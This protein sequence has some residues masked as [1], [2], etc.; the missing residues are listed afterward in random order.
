M[1]DFN[2]NDLSERE[3]AAGAAITM[4]TLRE[5][6]KEELKEARKKSS[7]KSEVISALFVII[8]SIAMLTLMIF[9]SP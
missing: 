3:L 6:Q 9:M 1:S 5:D 8:S 2:L 4:Q 7:G